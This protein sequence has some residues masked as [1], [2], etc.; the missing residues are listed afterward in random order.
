MF[1]GLLFEVELFSKVGLEWINGC[2]HTNIA[3]WQSLFWD[4]GSTPP[5]VFGNWN[6]YWITKRNLI[7]CHHPIC[8]YMQLIIICNY[9]LSFLQLLTILSNLLLFLQLCCNYIAINRLFIRP[10]GLTYWI[11]RPRRSFYVQLIANLVTFW[12]PLWCEPI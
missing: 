7:L 8:N 4:W 3:H 11:F 9:A 6:V 10:Y 5:V 12:L 1:F 2:R